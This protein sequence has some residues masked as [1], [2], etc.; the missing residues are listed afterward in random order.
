MYVDWRVEASSPLNAFQPFV[1]FKLSKRLL[2]SS[3]LKRYT[4]IGWDPVSLKAVSVKNA[5]KK[6]N[7]ISIMKCINRF[8][9]NANPGYQRTCFDG[10]SNEWRCMRAPS[11]SQLNGFRVP[12]VQL[13]TWMVFDLVRRKYKY[14]QQSAKIKNAVLFEEPEI[15]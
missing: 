6:W 10:E 1:F 9:R 11:S 8:V 4:Y 2:H 15:K 14:G 12:E 3:I 5:G 7:I 13:Y